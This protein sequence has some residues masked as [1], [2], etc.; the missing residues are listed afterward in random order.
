MPVTFKVDRRSSTTDGKTALSAHAKEVE[1][2]ACYDVSPAPDAR[3]N[4]QPRRL[5]IIVPLRQVPKP[6]PYEGYAAS[7]HGPA[8]ETYRE[9]KKAASDA[10][11]HADADAR[12]LA[13][14]IADYLN[15]TYD[16]VA[17][18]SDPRLREI[19]KGIV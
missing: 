1:F 6:P 10:R 2:R 4:G 7:D 15:K 9:K 8:A 3:F 17:T 16:G 13:Y 14:C 11:D 19:L 5:R 18:N 12:Y